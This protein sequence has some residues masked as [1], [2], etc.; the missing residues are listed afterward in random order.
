M[1][2]TIT[3]QASL[4]Y[5]Y[6]DTDASVLSNIATA[7]VNQPLTA[8]KTALNGTYREGDT[9]TFVLSLTNSGSAPLANVTVTDDLGTYT[10]STLSLTPYTILPGARLFLGGTDNGAISPTVTADGAVFTIPSLPAGT[11]ALILYQVRL[12]GTAPLAAGATITN[13]ATVTAPALTE[14]VAAAATVTAAEY[15][16]VAVVKT[17]SPA[18]L[19]DGGTI[20][21]TFD[22][23]NRGNTEATNIVLTDAFNPLPT[24]ITV[25]RDGVVLDATDYTF[26]GGVLTVPASG[27]TGITL[28]AATL[29]Q[30]EE[31]GAVTLTPS[32]TR[33]TV[34]GTL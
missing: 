2:Q 11:N 9:L 25:T 13:T 32:S 5:R 8:S 26:T 19:T 17:M 21:Y 7:V 30:N 33:I 10:L 15:A 29:T 3:N 4:S 28:P 27:S 18:T 14:D 34:T 24:A 23:T 12:T 1:A 6:G 31:T 20:T 22:I 16:D